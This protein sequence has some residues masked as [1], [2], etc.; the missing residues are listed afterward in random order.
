MLGR[1][2]PTT[3]NLLWAQER[4]LDAMRNQL[5]GRRAAAAYAE[6][7]AICDDDMEISRHIGAHG[8]APLQE[9]AARKAP[10]E[11]VNVLNHGNAG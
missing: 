7:V 2:R 4:M 11:T 6:A 5:P 9:I 1:S 8:V 3:V 10:G